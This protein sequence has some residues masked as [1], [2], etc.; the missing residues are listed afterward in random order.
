MDRPGSVARPSLL[1]PFSHA[2]TSLHR[3]AGGLHNCRDSLA[4]K[5]PSA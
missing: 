2:T 1:A 3:K 4:M 5:Y